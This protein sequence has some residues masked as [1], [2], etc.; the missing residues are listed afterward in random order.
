MNTLRKVD[1][2]LNGIRSVAL[3][4]LL[5][6]MMGMCTMNVVLRYLI[7]GVSFLRPFSWVNEMM[8]VLAIWVVFL[9]AG[10]GVRQDAHVS[11]ESLTEKYLPA[12]ASRI[13]RKAAQVI[14]IAVLVL[15]IVIGIQQTIKMRRSFLQNLP[16]SNAWFY[17]AIPVGCA[18]LLYEYV[19][20]LVFGKN[21]FAPASGDDDNVTGA[22]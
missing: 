11:L 9:A 7:K 8:Q 18:Y 5:V 1:K 12:K 3:V 2:I 6:S 13:L 16:I 22:F 21:P 15:L 19:L 10:L 17:A 20:I 4:V 14:V